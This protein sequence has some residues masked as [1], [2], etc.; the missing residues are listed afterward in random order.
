MKALGHG[1]SGCVFRQSDILTNETPQDYNAYTRK[2]L[3]TYLIT[4]TY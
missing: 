3:H 4:L 1:Y 2:N